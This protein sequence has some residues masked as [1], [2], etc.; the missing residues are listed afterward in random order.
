MDQDINHK[1]EQ[2]KRLQ[3]SIHNLDDV[4]KEKELREDLEALMNREEVMRSQKARC[5][6]I[7]LGD[8]NTK[9][10]QIVVKQRRARARILHLKTEDGNYVED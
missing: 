8:R 4:R 1:K 9:F 10:F 5:N 6:W 7:I 2:P 3:N